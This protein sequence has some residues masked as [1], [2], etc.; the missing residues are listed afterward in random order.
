[1]SFS[2]SMDPI[3]AELQDAI[4]DGDLRRIRLAISYGAN[5][6]WSAVD[7]SML[8]DVF[9]ERSHKKRMQMLNL[10]IGLGARPSE[11]LDQDGLL[12]VA[13]FS[14]NPDEIKLLLDES[15]NPN[16]DAEAPETPYDSINFD[17]RYDLWDLRLPIEP[18]EADRTNEDTWLDFMERCAQA[19]QST[20]PEHLRLLRQYGALTWWER[21]H[22]RSSRSAAG[23]VQ[24]VMA[25]GQAGAGRA[26]LDWANDEG[27]AHSVC[28]SE[29]MQAT[30]IARQNIADSDGTLAISLGA[31]GDD[32]LEAVQIAQTLGKPYL[33]IETVA[34]RRAEQAQTLDRWL[35][36]NH[37]VTLNVI[38][39]N[40]HARPGIYAA[41]YTLLCAWLGCRFREV[42]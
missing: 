4:R 34:S 7:E 2:D 12:Y 30:E 10:L 24:R 5:P 18:T 13:S 1:M 14:K 41:T 11:L 36:D 29:N 31:P 38:G 23:I 17:Y 19:T 28:S 42:E 3:D 15:T 39:P 32:V 40:E 20:P 27:I 35:H 9:W 21:E 22:R 37:I 33:L 25:S 6:S 16:A 8:E 26:A